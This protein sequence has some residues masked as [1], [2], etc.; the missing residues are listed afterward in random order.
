MEDHEPCLSELFDCVTC[1]NLIS[2]CVGGDE[3]VPLF[4]KL[5]SVFSNA[6]GVLVALP[7]VKKLHL[8][9]GAGLCYNVVVF[10]GG[11]I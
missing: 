11:V 4:M 1:Q 3:N 8:Y 5:N 9:V 7:Y 2:A 10:K 6:A